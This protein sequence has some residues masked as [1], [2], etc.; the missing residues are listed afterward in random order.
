MVLVD[1]IVDP[2][3]VSIEDD[4][5]MVVGVSALDDDHV[6]LPLAGSRSVPALTMT[7]ASLFSSCSL[8]SIAGLSA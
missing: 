5:T 7:L 3:A 8:Y 1:V 2:V 6:S 4:M